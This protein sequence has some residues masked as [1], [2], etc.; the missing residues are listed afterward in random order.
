MDV[1]EL[2]QIRKIVTAAAGIFGKIDILVN[3]AGINRP[4]PGLE[5]S[6]ENWEDHFNTNVRGGFFVAQTAA[7]YM[8]KNGWDRIIFISSQSGLVGIPGQPVYCS[9]KGAAI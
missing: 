2:E 7:P 4:M 6:A 3:N 9:T 8:I 1:R 5:V